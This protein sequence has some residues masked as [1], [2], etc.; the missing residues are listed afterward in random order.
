[1]TKSPPPD[2]PA[3]KR[4]TAGSWNRAFRFHFVTR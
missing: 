2:I 1:M 3:V 4:A